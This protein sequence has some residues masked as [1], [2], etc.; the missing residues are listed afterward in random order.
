MDWPARRRGKSEPMT[1]EDQWT[2]GGIYYNYEP[3]TKYAWP[4]CEE[5]YIANAT[6]EVVQCTTRWGRALAYIGPVAH[7][8]YFT[9]LRKNGRIWSR[10]V[11]WLS[12]AA[13]AV[14]LLGLF[15]GS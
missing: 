11:I 1:E 10:I 9:P 8:L 4:N 6:G 12:G 13:T 2:V 15:A 7:W 14:A 3:I 5:V